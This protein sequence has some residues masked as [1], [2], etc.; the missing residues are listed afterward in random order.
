MISGNG[1]EIQLKE[2]QKHLFQ[3]FKR[4]RRLHLKLH[5]DN[6]RPTVIIPDVYFERDQRKIL[7]E[8]IARHNNQM[9]A[10]FY[11]PGEEQVK[12]K[13]EF[14]G[15]QNDPIP[16]EDSS[17]SLPSPVSRCPS[18][19]SQRSET[20]VGDL[21]ARFS[22]PWKPPTAVQNTIPS[23]DP[24]STRN[25]RRKGKSKV[26]ADSN[27]DA[28]GFT[29]LSA[30]A[31]EDET[32]QSMQSGESGLGPNSNR[33]ASLNAGMCDVIFVLKPLNPELTFLSGRSPLVSLPKST[34]YQTL[35]AMA[36]SELKATLHDTGG[37][38]Y[39]L[40][41]LSIKIWVGQEEN[42]LT[43]A[44]AGPCLKDYVIHPRHLQNGLPELLIQVDICLTRKSPPAL[45]PSSRKHSLR[46]E[47]STAQPLSSR[48]VPGPSDPS[49]KSPPTN[50]GINACAQR[51]AH[52]GQILPVLLGKRKKD[53]HEPWWLIGSFKESLRG[54]YNRKN[55]V[56]ACIDPGKKIVR[57]YPKIFDMYG[58][59]LQSKPKRLEFRSIELT[60][61]FQP[62]GNTRQTLCEHLLRLYE[63][64][65]QSSDQTGEQAQSSLPAASGQ[66]IRNRAETNTTTPAKAKQDLV[67]PI[68]PMT[69]KSPVQ[70]KKFRGV[71]VGF[72][73]QYSERL[74]NLATD[75]NRIPTPPLTDKKRRKSKRMP[76]T[77]IP[78]LDPIAGDFSLCAQ[79]DP[80][81]ENYCE[82]DNARMAS[83]G[84]GSSGRKRKRIE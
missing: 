10:R 59:K 37:S 67:A 24:Q 65:L 83:P 9:Y 63:Q 23:P 22:H 40:D 8:E 39:G 79:D 26:S 44:T 45:V 81:D 20:V 34:T 60:A 84:I 31:L 47:Q 15:T 66:E 36:E 71:T 82:E 7:L 53:P 5:W 77:F 18:S 16:I 33:Q 48:S 56:I 74:Q 21:L 42:K 76:L 58:K 50:A 2:F 14:K 51:G 46:P 17:Q 72:A 73:K 69:P 28:A 38:R 13:S 29:T 6:H 41:S 49:E 35:E 55:A 12:I 70:N 52:K 27:I 4:D 75:R 57:L 64:V 54:N 30:P 80:D 19:S 32:H 62:Y 25:N 61:E 68:A 78:N 43:A 1:S 11:D 3:V